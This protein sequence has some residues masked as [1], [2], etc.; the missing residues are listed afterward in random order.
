M[1]NII[2]ILCIIAS[3]VIAS[4]TLDEDLN[5]MP[6]TIGQYFSIIFCTAL[7]MGGAF[8]L[9]SENEKS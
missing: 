2:G 8:L 1:K 6:Q 3:I 4:M 5:Y 7:I 9:M